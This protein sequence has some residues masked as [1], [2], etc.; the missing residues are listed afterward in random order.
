MVQRAA[1]ITASKGKDNWRLVRDLLRVD[2]KQVLA[3][4]KKKDPDMSKF[5]FIPYMAK[6]WLGRL[7]AESFA[8]RIFSNCNIVLTPGNMSLNPIE[9]GQLVVLR[10]NKR[11]MQYMKK[12]YKDKIATALGM[13]CTV[14]KDDE[15]VDAVD[16]D[17]VDPADITLV[18]VVFS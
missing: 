4:A 5:G 16:A 18:A 12:R 3:D 6:T 7:L 10:M 13:D 11:F 2:L 14:F 9:M 8:E 15:A 1:E 17:D